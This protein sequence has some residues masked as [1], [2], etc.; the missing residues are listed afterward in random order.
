MPPLLPIPHG[1]WLPVWALGLCLGAAAAARL[2]TGAR[3]AT[4]PVTQR[5]REV[6]GTETPWRG[7]ELDTAMSANEQAA[8]GDWT[9]ILLAEVALTGALRGL[10]A[11]RWKVVPD[12]V[13][14]GLPV[15]ALIA[16]PGCSFVIKATSTWT[17]YDLSLLADAADE[18]HRILGAD[19]GPVYSCLAVGALDDDPRWW[20][21]RHGHGAVVT[22]P[23]RVREVLEVAA[24]KGKVAEQPCFA[25]NG[26]PAMN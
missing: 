7:E 15:S 9:P 10:D 3:A 24:L 11:E 2:L 26:D 17:M 5:L 4:P 8:L 23:S 6:D 21:D 13:L 22:A 1:P 20:F 19:R 14:A 18:A 25:P 12:V 16:G